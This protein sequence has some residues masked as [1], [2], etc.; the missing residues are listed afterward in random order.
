MR[1]LWLFTLAVLI[2]IGCGGCA[3]SRTTIVISGEVEDVQIEA[4]YELGART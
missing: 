1:W 3:S 2:V 4:R